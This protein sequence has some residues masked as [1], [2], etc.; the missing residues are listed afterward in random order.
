M[1]AAHRPVF[2]KDALLICRPAPGAIRCQSLP[3]IWFN[4]L[5]LCRLFGVCD[6]SALLSIWSKRDKGVIWR[7]RWEI[8]TLSST[9]RGDDFGPPK[10]KVRSM[11]SRWEEYTVCFVR[12]SHSRVSHAGVFT[13]SIFLHRDSWHFLELKPKRSWRALADAV[14]LAWLTRHRLSTEP[15]LRHRHATPEFRAGV[16]DVVGGDR[17]GRVLGHAQFWPAWQKTTTIADLAADF[18]VPARLALEGEGKMYLIV[19]VIKAVMASLMLTVTLKSCRSKW[20]CLQARR[21]R[22]H[23]HPASSRVP[24]SPFRRSLT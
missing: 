4:P 3:T 16:A 21:P 7:I 6:H 11:L 17:L 18:Y 20:I 2:N 22:F 9:G 15:H 10:R 13:C 1:T 12:W 5:S 23:L 8:I 24:H 19:R 14:S